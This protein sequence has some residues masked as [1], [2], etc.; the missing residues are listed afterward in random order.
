M[1]TF[2]GSN[3]ATCRFLSAD[4]IVATL[5]AT[6]TVIPGETATLIAGRLFDGKYE[7]DGCLGLSSTYC[8]RYKMNTAASAIILTPD[9]ALAPNPIISAPDSD[10]SSVDDTY[11][12]DD[13]NIW[14]E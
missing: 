11:W 4:Q 5:P 7:E 9:N 14:L 2:T 3:D 13:R 12:Y 6:A 1:I 8:G 10:N